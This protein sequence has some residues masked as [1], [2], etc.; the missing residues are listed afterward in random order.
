MPARI[1][2]DKVNNMTTESGGSGIHTDTY[3]LY[4]QVMDYKSWALTFCRLE[5]STPHKC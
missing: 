4:S 3:S 5:W 2:F 1:Y